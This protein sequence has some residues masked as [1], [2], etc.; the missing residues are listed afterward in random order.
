M[1]IHLL[2]FH[3]FFSISYFLFRSETNQTKAFE[4]DVNQLVI[5]KTFPTFRKAQAF[6]FECCDEEVYNHDHVTNVFK[7]KLADANGCSA[8]LSVIPVPDS[9][10]Y[11]VQ[12]NLLHIGHI[13]DPPIQ[14][15]Q[16]QISQAPQQEEQ[17]VH[18]LQVCHPN[19]MANIE[20]PVENVQPNPNEYMDQREFVDLKS[21][22]IYCRKSAEEGLFSFNA[23]TMTWSCDQTVTDHENG[24]WFEKPCPAYHRLESFPGGREIVS[25]YNY[26][27]HAPP[28]KYG[29][30]FSNMKN[31]VTDMMYSTK[32]ELKKYVEELTST[33]R[34]L[35]PKKALKSVLKSPVKR[36]QKRITQ[37]EPVEVVDL[38]K[39]SEEKVDK[40]VNDATRCLYCDE[41][42]GEADEVKRHIDQVHS[43]QNDEQEA[44]SFEP[45]EVAIDPQK[46]EQNKTDTT[47]LL[48]PES[49]E[50]SGKKQENVKQSVE[51]ATKGQSEENV[52]ID[53]TKVS[54]PVPTPPTALPNDLKDN[55]KVQKVQNV[56][57]PNKLQRHEIKNFFETF[58][59][60]FKN[61]EIQEAYDFA[62]KLKDHLPTINLPEE[63]PDFSTLSTHRISERQLKKI[64]RSHLQTRR[65]VNINQ[66]S[67]TNS[68]Y[69]RGVS[70][71]QAKQ[72]R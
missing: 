16:Q 21:A 32:V 36:V 35:S 37:A 29:L 15:C 1:I 11:L 40:N 49:M 17:P 41:K 66:E 47:N 51:S 44:E 26:H 70:K 50:Q 61:N 52:K 53:E 25:S 4:A 31:Q 24:L 8:M 72:V 19:P 69:N 18:Q 62:I 43:F 2:H 59:N 23:E 67:V 34:R 20:I 13:N 10:Q 57:S 55:K 9:T 65:P 63:K 3:F 60:F 12:G 5:N 27:P 14:Q 33:A 39:E 45:I 22:L 6:A 68:L 30:L 7:C 48:T 46:P 54:K 64:D 28:D 56:N 42:F 38:E 71:V 58:Q